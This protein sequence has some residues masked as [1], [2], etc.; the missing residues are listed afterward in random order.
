[1]VAITVILAAVIGTFVLGLGENVNSTPQVTWDFDAEDTGNDGTI[2]QIT[3]THNGGD[4]IEA[5]RLNVTGAVNDNQGG[6]ADT[7]VAFTDTNIGDFTSGD[8]VTAGDQLVID[9]GTS[10]IEIDGEKGDVVRIVFEAE[11]SG[12][13][14]VIGTYELPADGFNA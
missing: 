14:S 6:S 7:P 3:I 13:S 5:D 2:D 12:S 10:N 11:G 9:T 4:S 1:M 8:T